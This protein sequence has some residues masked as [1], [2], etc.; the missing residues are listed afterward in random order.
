MCTYI[1]HV[2]VCEP[3]I[4]VELALSFM[5]VRVLGEV[6]YF[7]SILSYVITGL[8]CVIITTS[9]TIESMYGTDSVLVL[10]K[11]KSLV[12]QRN[13]IILVNISALKMYY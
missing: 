3:V 1:L 2:R 13:A 10:R 11:Y 8:Y 5:N 4:T 12:V 7:R 9:T 6:G